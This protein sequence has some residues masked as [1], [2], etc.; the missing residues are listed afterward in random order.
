MVKE[1]QFSIKINAPIEEVF[2]IRSDPEKLN[3][4]T[5]H[6]KIEEL[7]KKPATVGAKWITKSGPFNLLKT[8]YLVTGYDRPNHLSRQLTGSIV[9]TVED[10]LEPI[11]NGTKVTV[12]LKVERVPWFLSIDD[13]GQAQQ[14][15]LEQIRMYFERHLTQTDELVKRVKCSYTIA[16][17]TLIKGR[18]QATV[19]L[20]TVI[21]ANRKD[22]FD[23]VVT[24][25]DH[26][27]EWMVDRSNPSGQLDVSTDWPKKSSH[28]SYRV[29][30]RLPFN[31]WETGVIYMM[32][33]IPSQYALMREEQNLRLFKTVMLIDW[34][35]E[36]LE[37][38]THL[39]VKY[40]IVTYNY[41]FN[42]LIFA[43]HFDVISQ[44]LRKQ[45][46][47]IIKVCEKNRYFF[48]EYL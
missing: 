17:S 19:N 6:S 20:E 36:E 3:E 5:T 42:R 9:S 41:L 28:Y 30:S 22:V 44:E 7:T 40:E 13:F 11:T 4:I 45:I 14:D 33:C 38:V 1:F 18:K 25:V 8:H 27:W 2:N 12:K 10:I 21:E 16:P 29:R 39:K 37:N 32:E 15:F 24:N 46:A 35:F 31:T 48:P 26:F 34:K 47:N 23:I 43:R